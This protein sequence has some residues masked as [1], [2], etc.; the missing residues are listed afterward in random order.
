MLGNLLILP[1]FIVSIISSR[2]S[3]DFVHCEFLKT[4]IPYRPSLIYQIVGSH[5][6]ANRASKLEA[7]SHQEVT[8][9]ARSSL[10]PPAMSCDN[11]ESGFNFL[12]PPAVSLVYPIPLL[13]ST[14]TSTLVLVSPRPGSLV[15]SFLV[16][17]TSKTSTP[18]PPGD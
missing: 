8:P 16:I 6:S 9:Y 12:S 5:S 4:Q 2:I 3:L 10:P 14:E 17:L 15:C 1:K 11:Q 7:S 13:F 18:G